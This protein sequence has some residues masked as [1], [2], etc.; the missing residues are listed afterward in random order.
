MCVQMR[1]AAY[2]LRQISPADN[3]LYLTTLLLQLQLRASTRYRQHTHEPGDNS[4]AT[5]EYAVTDR[6]GHLEMV[7]ANLATSLYG[8]CC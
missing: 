7:G 3:P 5:T 1:L 8:C 2:S 4:V 6:H